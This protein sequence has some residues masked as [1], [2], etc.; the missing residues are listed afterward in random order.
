MAAIPAFAQVAADTSEVGDATLQRIKAA[1]D[2]G[3]YDQAVVPLRDLHSISTSAVSPVTHQGIR[4]ALRSLVYSWRKEQ[5]NQYERLVGGEAR[6]ALDLT[7]GCPIAAGRIAIDYPGTAAVHQISLRLGAMALENGDLVQAT[8]WLQ[9]YLEDPQTA[10]PARSRAAV[11]L[12]LAMA[13]QGTK[14][15]ATG[16]MNRFL[17]DS[18]DDL[19][20]YWGTRSTAH[21][22]GQRILGAMEN[23]PS[24]WPHVGGAPDRGNSSCTTVHTGETLVLD[25]EVT[26]NGFTV[27]ANEML[28]RSTL[29][30]SPARSGSRLC[31][32]SATLVENRLWS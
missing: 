4:L 30:N 21:E 7:S 14:A 19:A 28:R 23:V 29:L 10:G 3:R 9:Y 25:G 6:Q 32:T 17:R 12:V 24:T 22:A 8:Q 27:T 13:M 31:S 16:V 5:R 26:V 1:F 20:D 18:P 15:E 11:M 2:A